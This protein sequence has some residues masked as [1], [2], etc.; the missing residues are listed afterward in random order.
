MRLC[1]FFFRLPARI[2]VA[3]LAIAAFAAQAAPSWPT[4]PLRILVGFPGG[5]TPDLVARTIAEPLSQKLGQP[6][7]VENKPGASGN[8]AADL[9]AKANDAHTLGVLINGNLTSAKMLYPQL[10]YDPAQDFRPV[11]LLTT[12][13]LVLVAPAGLPAGAAFLAKA[14]QEGAAWNY[15]SVGVG[16]V[17]HLGMELLKSKLPGLVAV[18]VP[19]PGNPQILT[20]MFGGD[21]QMALMPP[22]L[23]LPQVQA[24]KL[25][26]IGLSSARSPLMPGVP[27][28]AELGVKDFKLEVWTALVAPASLPPQD[29]ARLTQAV[30]QVMAE[31]EVRAQ[32]AA[33][34]WQ[35][36]GSTPAGLRQ[37]IAQETTVLGRIIRERGITLN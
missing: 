16:S 14:R 32:L 15:G 26:A 27:A 31:P 2:G 20:A 6:V 36:V 8:I 21:V 29:A 34:G 30:A 3:V 28:L 25:Q 4:Q 22:G 37:R 9:V 17:G 11:S 23:A 5:S 12:A 18:H 19:Y 7:I 13:P 1:A 33:Q 35:P 24:G 10:P